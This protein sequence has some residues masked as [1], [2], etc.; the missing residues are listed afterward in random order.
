MLSPNRRTLRNAPEPPVLSGY[1][2]LPDLFERRRTMRFESVIA[3]K[4]MNSF[5]HFENPAYLIGC[6]GE[7]VNHQPMFA[8][9]A[10]LRIIRSAVVCSDV[11][12]PADS[13]KIESTKSSKSLN[14][15]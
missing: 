1:I 2:H 5:P 7:S 4:A 9:E 12:H 13:K 8:V 14:F 10:A 6:E 15:L 11:R 3:M